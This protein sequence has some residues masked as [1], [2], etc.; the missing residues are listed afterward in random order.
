MRFMT[1]HI[2]FG[3][4]TFVFFYFV[5][6]LIYLHAPAQEDK[7]FKSFLVKK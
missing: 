3:V 6:S 1:G 4:S 7:F 5:A 2:A